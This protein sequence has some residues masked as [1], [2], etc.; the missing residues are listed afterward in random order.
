MTVM[1]LVVASAHPTMALAIEVRSELTVGRE[2]VYLTDDVEA[3]LADG[4]LALGAGITMVSDYAIERYGAQAL[5]E[6][7]GDKVS[8]GVAATFGPRQEERG[9]ASVDPHLELRLP[10]GVT[11]IRLEAGTLLRRID[12]HQRRTRVAIDQLQL[13]GGL[14]V[15]LKERWR[16]AAFGLYSFYD[17]NP[18]ASSLRDL[19]LGLAVTL[20][21]RPERW[22]VGG[23]VA[24]RLAPWM[25][26]ELGAAGV[27]YADGQGEAWVPRALVRLGAWRGFSM[28]TAMEVVVGVHGAAGDALREIGSVELEYER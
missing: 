10:I 25:W 3:E 8:A 24:R 20:A 11:T 5:L 14:E 4:Q 28:A 26:L 22:A 21:G 9:W 13:H 27:V 23:R 19:D 6:Y 2:F 7:R 16:L 15:T 1:L 12:A 17:P 18:A